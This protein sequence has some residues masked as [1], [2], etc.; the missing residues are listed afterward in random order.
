[1]DWSIMTSF[2]LYITVQHENAP[3]AGADSW[4]LS[5]SVLERG[6]NKFCADQVPGGH[7]GCSPSGVRS[8]TVALGSLQNRTGLE[9]GDFGS[10]LQKD[11][12]GGPGFSVTQCVPVW[13]VYVGVLCVPRTAYLYGLGGRRKK[14]NCIGTED[15]L[16]T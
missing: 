16:P 9:G 1:M 3:R 14:A 5:R 4:I 15:V 12:R 11:S 8:L 6:V 10:I 2:Q 7:R 13:K